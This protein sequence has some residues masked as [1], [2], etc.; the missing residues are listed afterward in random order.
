MPINPN[1]QR[2]KEHLQEFN[3]KALLREDLGWDNPK[4][5]PFTIDYLGQPF[6]LTPLAEKRG[7]QILLCSP[8]EKGRIPD[9]QTLKHIDRQVEEYAQEHVLIFV[10]ETRESQ[11]WLWTKHEYHKPTVYRI[12]KLRQGQSCE[13][14]AQSVLAL[15]IE[16]EQELTLT[17]PDVAN[18]L[19]KGFDVEKITKKF[20][21]RFKKEHAV[22]LDFIQG[23]TVQGDREWY[24]SVMLNRLMFI[25]FIQRQGFLDTKSKHVLDGD[26]EYLRNRLKMNQ[27]HNGSNTFHSFYRYFLVR[28]F[29][30]GLNAR[31]RTPELERLLGSVPYLDGG[32]FDIHQLERNYPDIQ[33][34][35][36]AFERLFDF[37]DEFNWH[38]DD[39]PDKASNEINPDILGY[40]FEKY[41]NQKQMGAYYTKEDITEY[42]SKNTIIPFIFE[43][44]EKRCPIAFKPDGPVWSLLCDNP[45][46]YIYEAVAKGR[47]LPLPPEIEVGL[48]DISQRTEWNKAATEEYALPTEIWREVVERHKRYEEV[49]ERMVTGAITSINDLIIS[50]L[51][52][53]QF[54]QDVLT[55]CEGPDLLLA[56]YESIE[57]V[58]VLDPTCGSGAFLFAALNILKP[59]YEA[60]LVRMQSFVNECDQLDMSIEP[61]E[62]KKYDQME[63]FIERFRDILKQV[64]R[65]QSRE[66]FILKSIIINNLYG[67]DIMQEAVEICKLRLFL[68][69]VA[70]VEKPDG[71]ESLPDIDFNV[72]AGNTLVGFTSLDE[73]RSAVGKDLSMQA[74]ADEILQRI[75]QRVKELG[76][77]VE[78][79]RTL[80]TTYGI[81]L[82]RSISAQYKQEIR[83]KREALRS[84]LDP[85]LAMEY[86]ID[87]NNISDEQ[88]YQRK[89]AEWLK[90]HQPFHWFLEFYGIM[91][92]GGFDVI[93]GNPPYVEYS[94][95]KQDYFVLSKYQTKECRNIYALIVEQATT[96]LHILGRLGVII[97][98]ASV[99]TDSYLPLQKLLV[100]TGELAISNFNDRPGKLFDRLEHIR[101]S[102]ILYTKKNVVS[103]SFTTKYNNWNTVSRSNLFNLIKYTN[104]TEFITDGSI[105]KLSSDYEKIILRKVLGQNK[106]LAS[107][108]VNNS[109]HFIYYTRKLSGF[110]QILD[111]IPTI[112]D[113]NGNNREPSEL[114]AISFASEEIRNIFLSL[115]NSN[116]FYW[117]LTVYSDCR[118]LNKRELYTIRFD[119][120][121]ASPEVG[122]EL[123][124]L[125]RSLMQDFSHRS[126]FLEMEYEKLGKMTIQCL[127]PKYSKPII[128]EID[129]VLAKH[130]GFTDEELDFIINY[131]RKYRVGIAPPI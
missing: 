90:T 61:Q 96:L 87:R 121:K 10:D 118:N 108:M 7:V 104:A 111:F 65:H 102:I 43:C 122:M 9:D 31:E 18:K 77:A 113:A 97:P 101:L 29:Y 22:F 130:Y 51:D 57:K 99:C 120:E 92:S 55:Y 131:D 6:T 103:S 44:V 88:Q 28:L 106:T 42:I 71:I 32:I 48:A 91:T 70:Q 119:I 117:F 26:R 30:E 47:E 68:K 84:E 4:I 15:A 16:L 80:Q 54:A 36:E 126:R 19:K 128:D 20:Y 66:Y 3:F 112:Y 94:R 35:D 33:I 5:R 45:D 17:Q 114:K 11:A 83:N 89:C 40:I 39:R 27:E 105:P 63:R 46:D 75:E 129:R 2:I 49:R 41:I 67:V 72:L 95:V 52:I 76:R 59:L 37:F 115:L 21:D 116:L 24:T 85:Y 60:C 124:M 125:S 8:D 12:C 109:I 82:D 13:L 127:Y 38:L 62:R 79:F 74:V 100:S 73:I 107:Y 69:L 123:S 64:A 58:T 34:P 1:K 50:N 110:V 78:H 98:V 53:R 14:L 23:I 93:I 56:F 25:Y 81:E 86:E